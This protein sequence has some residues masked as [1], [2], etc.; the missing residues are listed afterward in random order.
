MFVK[1]WNYLKQL[2]HRYIGNNRHNTRD[3]FQQVQYK[4]LVLLNSQRNKSQVTQ[5]YVECP[6]N[7]VSY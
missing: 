4:P 7:P 6:H 2:F 1:L 3:N 5:L